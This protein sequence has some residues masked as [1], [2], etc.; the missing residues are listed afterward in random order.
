MHAVHLN[1]ERDPLRRPPAELLSEWRTL[2]DVAKAASAAG[3]NVSVVQVSFRDE[4]YQASGI[5]C[6]FV[7]EMAPRFVSRRFRGIDLQ[8]PRRVVQQISSLEPDLIH[9]HGLSHPIHLRYLHKKLPD[10]PILVQDHADKPSPRSWRRY[11]QRWGLAKV[12][13]IAFNG[14]GLAK[15]FRQ[16]QIIPSD[17]RV[18]EILESSSW[19]TP[20]DQ[21]HAQAITGMYGNPCVLWIGDLNANKDPLMVI[22]AIRMA[23]MELSNPHL[24]CYFRKAPLLSAVRARLAADSQLARRVHLMGEIEHE[25]V[26]DLCRAADFLMLGSHREGS[27]YSIFE[28]FACGT[29]PLVTDIPSFRFLTANGTFGAISSPGDARAMARALVESFHLNQQELRQRSRSHFERS[30]SFEALGRQLRHAY[31]SLIQ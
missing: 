18:F 14:E 12:A 22:E 4:S 19:F 29:T 15:S 23:S 3:I 13:G 1:C 24:W 21:S 2:I 26:E 6:Y 5:P 17:L 25:K 20:G 7:A 16:A 30:L 9:F 11:L 31:E 10:I 8:L 27:G 28:A